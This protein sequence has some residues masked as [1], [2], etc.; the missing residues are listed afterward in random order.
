M[1]PIQSANVGTAQTDTILD[2]IGLIY[3]S[4]VES[5]HWRVFLQA[6][7]LAIRATRC[8][9]SLRDLTSPEFTMVCWYG[10]SGE[11]MQ[12][13]NDHFCAIDPWRIGSSGWPEGSVG[14]DTDLCSR[15]EMESSV[16]FREF[17]A[18]KEA[19]HG[20]GGTILVTSTGQSVIAAVRG[21][22]DGP[23]A[24]PEKAILRPLMPHL[25]R[26]ALLHGEL[27]SVRRQLAVFTEHLNRYPQ[28]LLL[29]DGGCRLLFANA[30]GREL[31]A[32]SDGLTLEN[33]RIKMASRRA[34]LAFRQAVAGISAARNAPPQRVDVVRPSGR[35]S[36]R[37]IL[38]PVEDSGTIP[39]GVSIPAVSIIAVDADVRVGLDARVLSELFCLTPAE[40]RVAG[41]LAIG[42]SIEEIAADSKAS[43]ET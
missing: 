32:R 22:G 10:W 12:L 2:L 9:L 15:E 8:T 24:E 36:Y 4:A 19:I 13:Y 29:A 7:V 1:G 43:V 34:D 5:S 14:T 40:A 41:K 6:F 35:E 25:K 21:A 27:G 33:G 30:A 17:Y 26:A 18:P 20:I 38:M 11:E 16:A 37:L 42:Q 31:A 3:D 23:F 39:L 28:A